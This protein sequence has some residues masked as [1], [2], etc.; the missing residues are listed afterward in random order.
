MRQIEPVTQQPTALLDGCRREV[1]L[2]TRSED[3]VPIDL[4][5]DPI[6]RCGIERERVR[7]SGFYQ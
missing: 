2:K 3:A 6:E 1:E 5:L 7:L 4:Y